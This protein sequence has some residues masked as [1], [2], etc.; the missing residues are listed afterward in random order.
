MEEGCGGGF[1]CTH[2]DKYGYGCAPLDG[3]GDMVCCSAG[4]QWDDPPPC[5]QG[6]MSIFVLLFCHLITTF[7][8]SV[9]I[10]DH[11][12]WSQGSS[13]SAL[14]VKWLGRAASG[15]NICCKL[16]LLSIFKGNTTSQDFY[17]NTVYSHWRLYDRYKIGKRGR[18]HWAIASAVYAASKFIQFRLCQH[19]PSSHAPLP[20]W[21]NKHSI[22][23]FLWNKVARTST[24][25]ILTFDWDLVATTDGI[26]WNGPLSMEYRDIGFGN[27]TP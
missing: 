20:F 6:W 21:Q 18:I 19:F 15:R 24:R 14:M 27:L 3:T 12:K 16:L 10:L 26:D 2:S 9:P 4:Q 8:N 13:R 25:V 5:I 23:I 1:T 17:N 7:L 11:A 22:L